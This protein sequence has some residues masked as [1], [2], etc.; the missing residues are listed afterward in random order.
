MCDN[1]TVRVNVVKFKFHCFC[2]FEQCPRKL[3]NE[4][5]CS[6]MAIRTQK[7]NSIAKFTQRKL[8]RQQSMKFKLCEKKA[9]YS[10]LLAIN[11]LEKCAILGDNTTCGCLWNS[12]CTRL[13]LMQL[14]FQ[15]QSLM[16]LSPKL[17]L[18]MLLIILTSTWNFCRAL[19]G[20]FKQQM[21]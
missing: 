16:L 12:N 1:S 9:L 15:R 11:S 4:N 2:R 7:S 5:F 6:C 20:Q 8:Y 10:V 19:I 13:C 21:M 17:T 18:T 3:F 14:Q